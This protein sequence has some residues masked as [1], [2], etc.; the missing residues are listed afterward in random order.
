[1]QHSL[2]RIDDEIKGNRW[3]SLNATAASGQF[4][5]TTNRT[6]IL[7]N[8]PSEKVNE[9]EKILDSLKNNLEKLSEAA[10][11]QNK[12]EFLV[13]RVSSLDLIG[14]LEEMLI[15][16][17]PYSIPQ[18][19]DNLPR[20]L[21]R[22]TVEINT[23]KGKLYAIIDGYNAPLT[24]GSFIDLAIK[25]FYDGL[26]FNRAEDF[27]VLQNGDP[28]GSDVGYIDPKTGNERQ[29]PLE[30]K[31]PSENKPFYNQTFDDLGIYKE[32]PV[33]PF[34]TLGTLGWAHS[35]KALNDGSSQFFMFLYEAELTPAG[36]NL[37][38]GRNAAFGYVVKGNELLKKLDTN[39]K[40]ISI[41][42][43]EGENLLKPNA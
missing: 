9:F 13:Q 36:L 7:S 30:I 43:L 26:P 35:E 37:I 23:N 8:V 24:A 17:F 20:L 5:L 34:S 27:Y 10:S 19:Y 25:G 16:K 1:M 15:E 29:I 2:E 28:E 42:I 12:D 41:N 22:A 21:G 40:I 33:L 3:N 14:N 38:D 18:K 6:K 39:D 4:L 11:S 31:I 32:T